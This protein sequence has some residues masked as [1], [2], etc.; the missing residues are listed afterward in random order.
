M[1]ARPRETGRGRVGGAVVRMQTALVGAGVGVLG[2]GVEVSRV[3]MKLYVRPSREARPLI[4]GRMGWR[5]GRFWRRWRVCPWLSSWAVTGPHTGNGVSAPSRKTRAHS[6]MTCRH[7]W[8]IQA[9][10]EASLRQEY[11]S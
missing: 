9:S 1:Q 5:W 2:G 11:T 8:C 4:L 6:H 7:G 10:E 3:K